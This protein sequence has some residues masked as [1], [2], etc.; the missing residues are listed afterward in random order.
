MSLLHFGG[1]NMPYYLLFSLLLIVA[2]SFLPWTH[3]A[4]FVILLRGIDMLDGQILLALTCAAIVCVLYHLVWR[5]SPR[6]T[7]WLYGFVGIIV[8]MVTGFDLFLFYKNRYPTGP[9]IYLSFLGGVQ[10]LGSV[11]FYKVRRRTPA[12][13]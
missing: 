10:L 1:N 2:G 12:L 6:W 11:V 8:V 4:L 3:P 13:L 5:R 9:G 7:W